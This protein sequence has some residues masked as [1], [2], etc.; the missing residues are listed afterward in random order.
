MNKALTQFIIVTIAVVILSLLYFF[1]PA[2]N[3][4]YPTC[5]FHSL[6]GL[7]CPGCGSQRAA[8]ALL[9]GKIMD[10]LDYNILFVLA[11]PLVCYSAFVFSWNVFSSKKI[12]QNIFYSTLFVKTILFLVLFFWV[13]RNIP[14]SP[15]TWLKA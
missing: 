3:N 14:V 1:Y 10:A 12:G 11:V 2:A 7:D 6:T 13:L 9:H 15:F 4:F 8:S 5:I